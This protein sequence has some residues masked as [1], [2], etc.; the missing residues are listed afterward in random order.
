MPKELPERVAVL[1]AEIDNLKDE[2][3]RENEKVYAYID[4]RD[5]HIKRG[6][7]NELKN[8][9]DMIM[10]QIEQLSQKEHDE[11]QKL[12]TQ[13][14]EIR[15]IVRPMNVYLQ[16]WKG[17]IIG[18]LIVGSTVSWLIVQRDKIGQFLKSLFS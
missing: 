10:Q 5:D 18:A 2:Y 9:F 15:S 4:K 1:E 3:F 17:G 16:K 12:S 6:L 11:I 7:Q 13:I 8:A 14:E